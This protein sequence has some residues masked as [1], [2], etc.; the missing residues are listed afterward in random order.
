MSCNCFAMNGHAQAIS[1]IAKIRH[2]AL[3]AV[4]LFG[5][6]RWYSLANCN[7]PSPYNG[8]EAAAELIECSM[9]PQSA[10]RNASQSHCDR[11][12]GLQNI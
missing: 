1:N 10:K 9:W 5:V 12:S 2:G 8:L 7:S 11:L 3:K 6:R 4:E